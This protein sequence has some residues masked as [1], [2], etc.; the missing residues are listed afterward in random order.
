MKTLTE[1]SARKPVFQKTSKLFLT[2][3]MLACITAGWVLGSFTTEAFSQTKNKNR[4]DQALLFSL[5]RNGETL[6]TMMLNEF[7][8]V[9]TKA[10]Y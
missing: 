1:N 4:A 10:V 5:P 9:S 2:G 7:V 3:S 6:P 8:V